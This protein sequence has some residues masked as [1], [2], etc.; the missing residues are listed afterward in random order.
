MVWILLWKYGMQNQM[1]LQFSFLRF[2]V[3]LFEGHPRSEYFARDGLH[4]NGAGIDKME[5][6]VQQA[7]ASKYLFQRVNAWRTMK[8]L[9]W[10]Y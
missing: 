9:S 2:L 1:D 6:V 3:F 4:L 8:L 10:Y 7:F 5:A